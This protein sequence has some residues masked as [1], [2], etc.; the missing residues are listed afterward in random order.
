MYSHID[1]FSAGALD[2]SNEHNVEKG[3]TMSNLSNL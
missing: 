3:R 2:E 1:N